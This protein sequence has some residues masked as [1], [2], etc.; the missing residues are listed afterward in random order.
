[1][2]DSG[3]VVLSSIACPSGCT[4][5]GANLLCERESQRAVALRGIILRVLF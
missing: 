4:T 1:M 2:I 3:E 5:A